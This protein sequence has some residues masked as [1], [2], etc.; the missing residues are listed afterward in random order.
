MSE[1]ITGRFKLFPSLLVV[2]SVA[3]VFRVAEIYNG[4]DLLSEPALAQDA[5]QP[6]NGADAEVADEN[7]PVAQAPAARPPIVVGLP[8]SEED[9]I[10]TQLRARREALDQRSRQLDLQEQLL[11]STE[12]KIADKI[13]QL[14]QLEDAIKEHL[15]LFDER[16]DGQLRSIVEVYEKMKPK[17]AAPRFEALPLQ[18]QLDLVTRMK[19]AKVAALM[20]K[21]T[22]AKA[23]TLTKELATRAAP[24]SIQ[25]VQ[26]RG[27]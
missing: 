22:P 7:A 3:L 16:E 27:S 13:G 20:E 5:E 25:E 12:K 8:N 14:Q 15:R 11:E 10:I 6:E 26:Q 21:M 23:S 4:V 18:T 24:P 2:A 1:R 17:D 19:S 9:Q